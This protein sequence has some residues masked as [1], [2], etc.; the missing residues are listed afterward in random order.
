MLFFLKKTNDKTCL[1]RH[2]SPAQQIRN[3][4]C[5]CSHPW[6]NYPSSWTVQ[7]I[8]TRDI[9]M[10]DWN[11]PLKKIIRYYPPHGRLLPLKNT[12]PL[13]NSQKYHRPCLIN[14][15]PIWSKV[16]T[17]KKDLPVDW[18]SNFFLGITPNHTQEKVKYVSFVGEAV[19]SA[20]D[21]YY[22]MLRA[23]NTEAFFGLDLRI[24]NTQ[25]RAHTH[26][27]RERDATVNRR[28]SASDSRGQSIV[29][30]QRAERHMAS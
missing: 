24:S 6:G 27:E 16:L 20:M 15:I 3:V 19:N 28:R 7:K 21:R 25:V 4:Q 17:S 1:E 11:M 12:I 2:S 14:P 9:A 8:Y 29:K 22:N 30:V 10:G 23:H 18:T 26:T 13:N 5:S